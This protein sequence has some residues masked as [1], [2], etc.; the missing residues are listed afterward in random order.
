MN[1][2]YTILHPNT[3]KPML[4]FKT[5]TEMEIILVLFDSIVQRGSLLNTSL[6]DFDPNNPQHAIAA[7]AGDS[8]LT[9][10][11]APPA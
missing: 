8:F 11:G 2:R 10:A 5:M 9:L 6:I 7:A 1:T 4:V 3:G